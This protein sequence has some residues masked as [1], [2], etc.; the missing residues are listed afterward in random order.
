MDDN[1]TEALLRRLTFSDV[2]FLRDFFAA[3]DGAESLA[4]VGRRLKIPN[5]AN[6]HHRLAR[7]P[8]FRPMG[9]GEYRDPDHSGGR[10]TVSP[11]QGDL[12]ILGTTPTF[13]SPVEPVGRAYRDARSHDRPVVHRASP[14]IAGTNLGQRTRSDYPAGLTGPAGHRGR[15]E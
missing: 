3:L 10:G 8:A 15:D 11:R 5:A 7:S 2:K 9:P 6:L 14:P 13:A 4:E 1:E 12:A